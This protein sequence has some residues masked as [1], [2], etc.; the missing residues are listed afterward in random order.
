MEEV[1]EGR[2][3]LGLGHESIVVVASCRGWLPLD[4]G[5]M[6][7]SIHRSTCAFRLYSAILTTKNE[8]SE[9]IRTHEKNVYQVLTD[10]QN[11]VALPF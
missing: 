8:L 6:K 1:R 10:L 5:R 4:D 9:E 2:A 11:V 3:C 7:M